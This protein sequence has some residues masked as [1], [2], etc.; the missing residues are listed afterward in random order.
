MVASDWAAWSRVR[1]H[2]STAL[3]YEKAMSL[4][5][6]SPAL[7]QTLEMQHRL[8]KGKCGLLMAVPLQ[9]ASYHIEMG[10]LEKAVETLERGGPYFGR[11]CAASACRLTSSG[12]VITRRWPNGTWPSARNWRTL[13]RL[14]RPQK[15]TH[16]TTYHRDDR[17]HPDSF[18]RMMKRVRILE[19]E[20]GEVINQITT[21][22]SFQ[23][24]L[25]AVPFETPQTAAAYGP[26]IIINHCRS[27]C[28]ILI[29][30][31]SAAPVLIQIAEGP[32]TRAQLKG[33]CWT[34]GPDI[35]LNQDNISARYALYSALYELVGLP[36]M[37]KLHELGIPEQSRVW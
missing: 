24:F 25:K 22:P 21:V 6:S 7:R 17:Q 37:E 30:L 14:G 32:Y 9:C 31:H 26:V 16:V 8:L 18:G 11:R 5:Q 4:M 20:R 19:H 23:D 12:K 10:F 36:V 1:L 27:R 15:R 34:L 29:I 2:L 3:A 28:D 33:N 35:S 13:P